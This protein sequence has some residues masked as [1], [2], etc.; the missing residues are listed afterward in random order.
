MNVALD[1]DLDLESGQIV[2][3]I[4]ADLVSRVGMDCT[5]YL[6]SAL[7]TPYEGHAAEADPVVRPTGKFLC[8]FNASDFLCLFFDHQYPAA[9]FDFH[10]SKDKGT[11]YG[12]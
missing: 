7:Q 1:F 4:H 8:V 12:R 2:G 5:C 9:V 3:L 11:S 10:T 6:P